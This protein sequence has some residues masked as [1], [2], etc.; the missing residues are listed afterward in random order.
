MAGNRVQPECGMRCKAFRAD[1]VRNRRRIL[2]AAR[3]MFA[4]LGPDVSMDRIAR[5]AGVPWKPPLRRKQRRAASRMC[6][7]RSTRY[8]SM[9]FG[10]RPDCKKNEC[11]Y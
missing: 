9:T 10:M 8:C 5:L 11:S 6:R 2:A 7:R 3:D 4:Q 1:A